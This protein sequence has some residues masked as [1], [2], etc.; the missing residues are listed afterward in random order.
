MSN[1]E[2]VDSK[3]ISG[4]NKRDIASAGVRKKKGVYA[5]SID[6]DP[7]YCRF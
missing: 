2:G 4:S 7:G 1:I 6:I 3:P 5:K